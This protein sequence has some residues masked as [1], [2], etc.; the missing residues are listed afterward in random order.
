LDKSADKVD[1]SLVHFSNEAAHQAYDVALAKADGNRKVALAS[2]ESQNGDAQ[3]ACKDQAESDY[4][5]ARADTKA[6]AE[7]SIQ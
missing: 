3:K 2:C 6:S 7:A 5:A 4:K 1:D